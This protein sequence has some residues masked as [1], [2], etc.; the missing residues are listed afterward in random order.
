[1]S[2]FEQQM[3]EAILNSI[4][5]IVDKKI[6][7]LDYNKT[8]KGLI[9]DDSQA[10]KGVYSIE[11]ETSVFTAYTTDTSLKKGDYVQV[12][13]SNNNSTETRVIINKIVQDIDEYLTSDDLNKYLDLSGNLV[14][15]PMTNAK[16]LTANSSL[17]E[18]MLWSYAGTKNFGRFDK[19]YLKA[20][21]QSLLPEAVNGE[22][23]LRLEIL[24][25]TDVLDLT[26][27]SK[28][29]IGNALNY[30]SFTTQQKIFNLNNYNVE[31]ISQISLYFYQIKDSFENENGSTLSF[32]DS[33]GNILPANLFVDNIYLSFGYSIDEL[34]PGVDKVTISLSEGYS[35]SYDVE[36]LN[37]K[38]D[39][40]WLHWNKDN[41]E[42][43]TNEKIIAEGNFKIEWYQYQLYADA[44]K[45]IALQKEE[46]LG[47]FSDALDEEIDAI[48]TTLVNSLG[49]SYLNSNNWQH[50]KDFDN[51]F[52]CDV[53]LDGNSA[54][55]EQIIAFVFHEDFTDPI[56]S[57]IITFVNEN[58]ATDKNIQKQGIFLT[59]QDNYQGEYYL[60]KSDGILNQEDKK[61]RILKVSYYTP[62]GEEVDLSSNDN[63]TINWIFDNEKSSMLENCTV[64]INPTEFIYTIANTYNP[65]ALNNTVGCEIR[66]NN[67]DFS[68]NAYT[69]EYS[70]TFGYAN[71]ANT[72]T[73]LIIDFKEKTLKKDNVFYSKNALLKGSK[74]AEY[75]IL[76]QFDTTGTPNTNLADTNIS[77]HLVTYPVNENGEKTIINIE[78]AVE[79]PERTSEYQ[80]VQFNKNNEVCLIPPEDGFNYNTYLIL[81]ANLNGFVVEFPLPIAADLYEYNYI[82]GATYIL[83]RQLGIPMYSKE[84]Y[85]IYNH[86]GELVEGT[87]AWNYIGDSWYE[88]SSNV[89][90]EALLI[91][92]QVYLDTH[93]PIGVQCKKGTD[94]IWSQ[95]ITVFESAFSSTTLSAWDGK[96][97]QINDNS[98]TA[99][100]IMAGKKDVVIDEYNNSSE[101]FTGVMM[102]DLAADTGNTL[103]LT[104]LYGFRKGNPSFGF[105]EDGTA[106]IGE[107]GIGRIQFDGRHGWISSGDLQERI[108]N[109]STYYK[110]TS[111]IDLTA[112]GVPFQVYKISTGSSENSIPVESDSEEAEELQEIKQQTGV[113]NMALEKENL[114]AKFGSNFHI[115]ANGNVSV[116]G[117]LI[118][119]KLVAIKEGQIASFYFN[120]TW[121]YTSSIIGTK[122]YSL[123]LS[124]I[125]I[126]LGNDISQGSLS[127]EALK[128]GPFY[129][130]ADG[131]FKAISGEIGG[132]RISEKGLRTSDGAY[133]YNLKSQSDNT[134][135]MASFGTNC[136]ILNDGTGIFENVYLTGNINIAGQIKGIYRIVTIS[137]Q[138]TISK[139]TFVKTISGE[140]DPGDDYVA[141]GIVGIVSGH[142]KAKVVRFTVTQDGDWTVTVTKEPYKK[143]KIKPTLWL[144]ILLL[145]SDDVD[146]ISYNFNDTEGSDGDN[147]IDN[148]GIEGTSTHS[149][150]NSGKIVIPAFNSNAA[151]EI[152][153]TA[154]SATDNGV[155]GD[156]DDGEI[157][158]FVTGNASA[159]LT[160]VAYL[161]RQETFI[162]DSTNLANTT[163]AFGT[164]ASKVK[165]YYNGNEVATK[166][167]VG[168]MFDEDDN[169]TGAS[170]SWVKKR[171][172][173]LA[174]TSTDAYHRL[175]M[176]LYYTKTEANNKFA[177]LTS[178][179]F[180]GTPTAPNPAV[181]TQNTQIATCK[182]VYD[183][184][185]EV[186]GPTIT[187]IKN[188]LTALENE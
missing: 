31:K 119:T 90:N 15:S 27:S 162:Q 158:A 161:D 111:F 99:P 73:N 74:D 80:L 57:N 187:A 94:I 56:S 87:F 35:L 54:T 53:V 81:C 18:K 41:T 127:S 37:S 136:F 118:A 146:D 46:R 11:Y 175:D 156:V 132:W 45:S 135:V 62:D 173:A 32:Q 116:K 180:T 122:N 17:E 83:Y 61:S 24:H 79:L 84:P 39:L 91:P 66:Y 176:S 149:S 97:V 172:H 115:S 151:T 72:E 86:N 112:Q 105:K 43:L 102:G 186:D 6:S 181:N 104:G 20:Q 152:S 185:C 7:E 131:T 150:G 103:P 177:P 154:E 13:I 58:L 23:G 148:D 138:Y 49:C 157:P 123:L 169:F 134:N 139:T 48:E 117:N 14:F 70:F 21:F 109:N 147:D 36:P 171:F 65:S 107:E 78:S 51:N 170:K 141:V 16:S 76:K 110:A 179:T 144:K 108:L 75:F 137:K 85:A 12:L 100:M 64:G 166:S 1:M 92:S 47:P 182:W 67:N 164:A 5:V 4:D 34:T 69:A 25:D 106:F 96:S 28:E 93:G 142:K 52:T 82:T 44:V 68:A 29:M 19:I 155:V 184:Y 9:I 60:Y 126:F 124:S 3:S 95:P 121:L 50:L 113:N 128:E 71:S 168:D 89:N 188:R 183:N 145:K 163:Y 8:I 114:I 140:I 167:Y 159:N 153:Y 88:I 101:V 129:V 125:G 98:V 2:D 178:P 42:L 165:L 130:L 55:Q 63:Y 133:T 26:F 77:W 143:K 120:D 38:V 174:S 22:Y 10:S 33:L 40:E 160:G 59:P 30:V